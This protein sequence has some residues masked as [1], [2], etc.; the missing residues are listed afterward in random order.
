MSGL[1]MNSKGSIKL[2]KLPLSTKILS[3]KDHDYC[4]QSAG[5]HYESPELNANENNAHEQYLQTQ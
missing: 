1:C 5:P 4:Q 2:V 3:K